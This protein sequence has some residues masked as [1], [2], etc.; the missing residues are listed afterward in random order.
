VPAHALGLPAFEGPFPYPITV[1]GSVVVAE[2][3]FAIRSLSSGGICTTVAFYLRAGSPVPLWRKY[4]HGDKL[5]TGLA[6][7]RVDLPDILAAVQSGRLRP[8]LVTTLTADWR[9]AP[10]VLLAPST[11][12]VLVRSRLSR[13]I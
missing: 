2:L 10:E 9:D 3:D 12:V 1:D 6:N 13:T 8:E 7:V 4:V 5:K 11:K